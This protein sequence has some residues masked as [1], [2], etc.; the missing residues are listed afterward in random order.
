MCLSK[1]VR[2]FKASPA[3]PITPLVVVLMISVIRG[4]MF[5]VS[6]KLK[7]GFDC[8]L[9]LSA[10]IFETRLPAESFRLAYWAKSPLALATMALAR[11]TTS[12]LSEFW[13]CWARVRMSA[14]VCP[15]V[16]NVP[17]LAS[18][19]RWVSSK[20]F[21]SLAL[22]ES[23]I[24]MSAALPE[25]QHKA[26]A[27]RGKQDRGGPGEFESAQHVRLGEF[28]RGGRGGE[29]IAAGR[30]PLRQKRLYRFLD[31]L[32]LLDIGLDLPAGAGEF[33]NRR[34]EG[35]GR[36]SAFR[37]LVRWR[38]LRVRRGRLGRSTG[39]RARLFKKLAGLGYESP[40]FERGRLQ[41]PG[42]HRRGVK[43]AGADRGACYGLGADLADVLLFF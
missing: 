35:R 18:R 29:S 11:L 40:A 20:V 13:N 8:T 14:M 42:R 9:A 32:T 5:S 25:P 37:G 12:A 36:R 39:L 28:G 4:P 31:L 30:L 19:R 2:R 7:A 38:E 41:S 16:K 3:V 1:D 33:R 34:V 22:I 24:P 23:K 27:K 26:H 10:R 15:V 21:C 17:I 6:V 43:G